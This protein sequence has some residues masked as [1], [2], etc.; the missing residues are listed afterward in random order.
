MYAIDI[1]GMVFTVAI[2]SV[3][4]SIIDELELPEE[5]ESAHIVVVWKW[6]QSIVTDSCLPLLVP[7]YWLLFY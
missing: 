7:T 1:A 6:L 5:E 4:Q 2:L 3:M